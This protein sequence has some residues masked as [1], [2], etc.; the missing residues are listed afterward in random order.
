MLYPLKEFLDNWFGVL[1]PRLSS[2]AR[3]QI[4]ELPLQMIKAVAILHANS[5]IL[6]VGLEPI[7]AHVC[8]I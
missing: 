3:R 2:F 4:P 7:P 1:V 8:L 6:A 5:A